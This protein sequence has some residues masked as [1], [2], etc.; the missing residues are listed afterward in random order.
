MIVHCEDDVGFVAVEGQLGDDRRIVNAA[1]VSF[2]KKKEVFDEDDAKLL[3]YL[4][5]NKHWSPFRHGM[6]TF[7]IK[8]PEFV[9]RQWYKHVVGAEWT[10]SYYTKDHAWNEI[11]LRYIEVKDFYVPKVFRKA[12]ENKKQGSG[13]PL[14]NKWVHSFYWDSMD[15]AFT[16]YKRLVDAG[17]CIEQARCVLPLSLYTQVY[18]TASLQALFNFIELR[19]ESHAQAEIQEYARIVRR[20]TWLCFPETCKAWK[21]VYDAD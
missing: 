13:G 9:L 11:S 2:G 4:A 1:R 6:I 19:T 16:N 17:V 8:A 5:K 20:L 10:S 3:R 14:E 7:H 18:W 21:D 12:P 15:Q